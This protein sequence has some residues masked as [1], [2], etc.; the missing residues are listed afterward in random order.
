MHQ[1]ISVYNTWILNLSSVRYHLYCSERESFQLIY[2][3]KSI[4]IL[5]F[6]GPN[7]PVFN[8]NAGNYGP[9]KTRILTLFTLRSPKCS[10]VFFDIAWVKFQVFSK[11]FWVNLCCREKAVLLNL[12]G[13]LLG[14]SKNDP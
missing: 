4:Q 11:I 9:V 7:F 5:S 6:S 10:F 2:C 14:R 8:P 3:V 12:L 13:Y 1:K